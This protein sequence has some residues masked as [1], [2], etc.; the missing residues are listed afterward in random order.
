MGDQTASL[1]ALP[2]SDT[3]LL[4]MTSSLIEKHVLLS[5]KLPR[6]RASSR[7]LPPGLDYYSLRLREYDEEDFKIQVGNTR[8]AHY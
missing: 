3:I 2:H 5:S 8:N 6:P 1:D 4:Y 7:S